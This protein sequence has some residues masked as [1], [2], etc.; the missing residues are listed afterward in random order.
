MP[1]FVQPSVVETNCQVLQPNRHI[2]ENPIF[3]AERRPY[4]IKKLILHPLQ[5]LPTQDKNLLATLHY[6]LCRTLH[7]QQAEIYHASSSAH[8]SPKPFLPKSQGSH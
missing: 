5:T 2:L 7:Q 6:F 3:H 1:L 8:P 4:S